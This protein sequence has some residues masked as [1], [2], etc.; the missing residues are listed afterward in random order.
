MQK[1]AD[2]WLPDDDNDWLTAG[3]W[4]GTDGRQCYQWERIHTALQYLP[5]KR[6][7]L[8]L[9]VG[10]HAGLWTMQLAKWFQ[11]VRAFE[12]IPTNIECW[13]ANCD[14]LRPACELVEAAVG[15]G[16]GSTELF[17]PSSSLS[18]R[19]RA[20]DDVVTADDE[21]VKPRRRTAAAVVPLVHL[22]AWQNE[23][24]DL[25]KVDVEGREYEV[26][27]GGSR[28]LCKWEP[29]VI[30][31]EK[32]DPL[33]RASTYLEGLGMKCVAKM[34]NDLVWIWSRR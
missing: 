12:P 13:H 10:A 27:Q 16:R 33:H 3:G 2:V 4:I 29:V 25:V 23:P 9:D 17:R 21:T 8:A 14:R 20:G 5:Q 24:V 19:E 34:K 28:V 18:W 32:H 15:Q 30:I 31:E 7:R 11:R 1:I 6:R 26:L 22:D